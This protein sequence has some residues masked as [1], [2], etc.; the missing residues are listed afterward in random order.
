MG[1]LNGI[2]AIWYRELKV[3]SR[4]KSRVISSI[5]TPVLWLLVIGGG[6]GS[7]VSLPGGTSYEAFI[8]PGVLV[9]SALF[10]SVFFGVY[11][12][13]DKKIDFLKEVL[14]SPISRSSMF[15]GKVIGGSTDTFIQTTILLV[16]GLVLI[17]AGMLAGLQLNALTILLSVIILFITTIGLVSVGLILGS[18]MSSLEGF[19]IVSSFLIFPMFFLSG[20]LFPIDN[21]PSW[22]AP[23]IF[24]DPLT[25]SVDAL[26]AVLLGSS[27]F[28]VFFDMAIV[29]L[30]AIVT[31]LAGTY[32][33][34]KMKL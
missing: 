33:F 10:S 22:L 7:V 16:I 25:Y 3:F 1:E 5:V 21:L 12:V 6:I 32:A 20:A 23:I 28:N 8:F 13:W 14:V 18:Q 19:Q 17:N 15:L 34:K 9:Q 11:I 4:E 29:T 31:V 30:F 26:R 27:H 24:I 2:Y